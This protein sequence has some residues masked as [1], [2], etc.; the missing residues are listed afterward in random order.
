MKHPIQFVMAGG[1]GCAAIGGI[2][3]VCGLLLDKPILKT[4]GCWFW[5]AAFII[6]CLPLLT[7]VAVAII[8]K[9]RCK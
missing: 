3:F 8:E 1:G 6:A 4:V 5:I 7:L 2:L 9:L